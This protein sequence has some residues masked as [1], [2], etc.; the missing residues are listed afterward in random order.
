MKLKKALGFISE[1][2]KEMSVCESC[3]K[4]FIC[5]ATINGCWCFKVKLSEDTRKELKSEFTDCLCQ[6]CLENY[7]AGE[8]K[9]K[10]L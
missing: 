2:Y 8:I 9:N 6:N 3:G 10:N 5:G 1:K 4:E 7:S